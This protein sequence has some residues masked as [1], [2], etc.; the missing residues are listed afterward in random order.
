M[1]N[2]DIERP[3]QFGALDNF[4]GVEGAGRLAG[5]KPRVSD[6]VVDLDFGLSRNET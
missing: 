5:L 2:H 3:E 4:Q 6:E 1:K